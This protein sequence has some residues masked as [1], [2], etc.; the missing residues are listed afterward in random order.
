M[1]AFEVGIAAM[2]ELDNAE[3][4]KDNE[5]EAAFFC[6][7]HF[8]SSGGITFVPNIASGSHCTVCGSIRKLDK[9]SRSGLYK[10]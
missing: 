2:E 1:T 5:S 7:F 10:S 8:S 3:E 4:D 6:V 9:M